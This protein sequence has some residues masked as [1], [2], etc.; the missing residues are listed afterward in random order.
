MKLYEVN[1]IE[2]ALDKLESAVVR[3][4]LAKKHLLDIRSTRQAVV[5]LR[6]KVEK[7]DVR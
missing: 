2:E 4:G 1:Q 7:G 5:Q 6:E 3:N